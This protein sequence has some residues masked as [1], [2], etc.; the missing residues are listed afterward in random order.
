MKGE[1]MGKKRAKKRENQIYYWGHQRYEHKKSSAIS[2]E[3]CP[4]RTVIIQAC[5]E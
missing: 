1:K 3:L 4:T 2:G 5:R